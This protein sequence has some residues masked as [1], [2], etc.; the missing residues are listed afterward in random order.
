[1]LKD[2]IKIINEAMD[3]FDEFI[4]A[5]LLPVSE[6]GKQQ[7]ALGAKGR[8]ADLLLMLHEVHLGLGGNEVVKDA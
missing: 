3:G 7:Y 8:L 4:F 2:K 6:D 1:M 5:I